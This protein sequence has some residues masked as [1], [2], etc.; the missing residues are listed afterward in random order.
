LIET[1]THARGMI[2]QGGELVGAHSAAL[3]VLLNCRE[4]PGIEFAVQV[5]S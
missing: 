1:V 4:S 3:Q 2:T 5:S